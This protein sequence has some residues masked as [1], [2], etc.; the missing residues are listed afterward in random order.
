MQQGNENELQ[1]S[2]FIHIFQQEDTLI[3]EQRVNDLNPLYTLANVTRWYT[4]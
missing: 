2:L 4:M 1:E 3:D